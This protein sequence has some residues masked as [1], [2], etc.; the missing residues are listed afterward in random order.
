MPSRW[1]MC[2]WIRARWIRARWIQLLYV[3]SK[4]SWLQVFTSTRRP[5]EGGRYDG[6][7]HRLNAVLLSNP[8]LGNPLLELQRDYC[9]KTG[10]FITMIS[11]SNNFITSPKPFSQLKMSR[12][13]V[14]NLEKQQCCRLMMQPN[15]DVIDV[16][17][18]RKT[19][20]KRNKTVIVFNHWKYK[21]YF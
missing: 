2:T 20:I 17:R 8:L 5:S 21:L 4:E 10:H 1:N 6:G 12:Q 19:I 18:H 3:Y 9:G 13:I 7:T 16:Q 11:W 14:W 15:S